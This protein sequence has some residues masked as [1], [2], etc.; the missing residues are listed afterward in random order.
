MEKRL[1]RCRTKTRL[2]SVEYYHKVPSELELLTLMP[3][4][5]AIFQCLSAVNPDRFQD[6]IAD[7]L[8]L[9]E[10]HKLVEVTGGPGDENWT[11]SPK[12]HAVIDNGRNA[13]TSFSR[14]RNQVAMNST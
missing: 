3:D 10:G 9:T 12:H 8:V 6:F 14:L 2:E 13:S 4:Q 1:G 5:N 11:F 7:A